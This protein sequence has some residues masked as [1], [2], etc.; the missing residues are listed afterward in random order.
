MPFKLYSD[1]FTDQPIFVCDVCD[2]PIF[3]IWNNKA[4]G[5]PSHDG[6]ASDVTV[7]H[8]TCVPPAGAVTIPLIDFLRLLVVQSR[9]GDLGSIGGLDK[10]C[11]EYPTGKGFEA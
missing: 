10:V 5:S 4:T 2:Q 6:Q 1:Q 11:V 7:H 8:A 3:D 9:P